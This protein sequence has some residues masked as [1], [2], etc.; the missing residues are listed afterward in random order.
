MPAADALGPLPPDTTAAGAD[1]RRLFVYNG[2]FLT[3]GRVR[4]ILDLSGYDIRLGLPGDGDMVGVWGMS[5]TAPRGEAVAARRDAPVLRVEDAFLRSL[6]PG[7][8]GEPPLGLMLDA[9]GVHF[10]PAQPSE[11]E[12]LLAT[13]PLDDT[14]LL[15]RARA[16]MARLQGSHL[17]KYAAIRTDIDPPPP[18]YVLVIDQTRGDASVTASRADRNTFREMLF[19]ARDAHPAARILVRSH[20]ETR[21]GHRP[22]YFE[23]DDLSEG[24]AFHDDPISPWL[25]LEGAVAV[26]TVSSQLGFE[27]I[28]AGHKP[29]VFGQPFYAG[30]GLTQ[31]FTPLDR[32]QRALTRAQLF[33][34]A[35]IL[36]PRWYDPFRDRLC[37]L[38]DVLDVLEAQ[39]RAWREDRAGWVACGMRL[40]KRR[41]MQRYFGRETPVRFRKTPGAP[42]DP[43]VMGWGLTAGD[44]MVRVEDGF[45]RSRGLGAELVPPVSL[46]LDDLGIYYDPSR[47]SR[48]EALIVAAKDLRPDQLRRAERLIRQLTRDGLTKYNLGD[49]LPDLP[50]LPEGR[51]ILVPG[52]VEDDASI[53]RGAGSVTTNAA[54]L[55]AVRAANPDAVLLYK[56][57][58]DVEAGLRAGAVDAEE[59]ADLVLPNSDP[60]ALLDMVD[61]VW[62]MTSGIGF[63]ALLRGK[64]V[65]CFGAPFYAGWGLTQDRGPI[66]PRRRKHQVDLTALVHATLIDY[67]RYWDPLT[68]APCPVEVVAER[69]AEG[70]VPHPGLANR[71]LAKLQGVFASQAH[72]WR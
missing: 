21:A 29:H 9:K 65:T 16:A 54:L 39:V 45:L 49:A 38:E 15:D 63:E 7:R 67:P 17:T 20:P 13:H 24:M 2:G 50:D 66:P 19:E 47:P 18:G 42:G 6:R 25:L 69:L 40:W 22:G 72:L 8:D 3:Q 62:T 1:P 51:L 59:R 61:E 41:H 10:D 71:L 44:N 34:A 33:A 27:A 46:V 12:E 14:A 36:Y 23:A 30:W 56:P 60:A 37:D 28:L 48:L 11:L 35:M 70:Q 32:R 52:Q 68:G 53:L 64:K 5:P 43:R 4:R 55:E 58:P 57:H 26:Y 31:D